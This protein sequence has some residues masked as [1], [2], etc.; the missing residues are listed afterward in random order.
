MSENLH[1]QSFSKLC[2]AIGS[3]E[4]S[5]DEIKTLLWLAKGDPETVNSI[6]SVINKVK[7]GNLED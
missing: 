1:D 6:C 3:V 7:G 5:P 4:L 2:K